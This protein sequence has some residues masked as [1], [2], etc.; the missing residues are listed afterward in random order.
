MKPDLKLVGK[1]K[2]VTPAPYAEAYGIRRITI[3]RNQLLAACVR[4]VKEGKSGKA[5]DRVR[6][7]SDWSGV[8]R[9]LIE[10]ALTS[11]R[12]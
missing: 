9:T 6:E 3:L 12:S 8:P 2:T 4:Y 11:L 1:T 7:A 5:P 10:A